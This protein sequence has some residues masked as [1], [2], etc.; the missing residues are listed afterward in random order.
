MTPLNKKS[1]QIIFIA[2]VI[3]LIANLV[4]AKYLYAGIIFVVAGFYFYH[5]FVGKNNTG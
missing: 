1:G 3:L 4:M 2:L 5:L